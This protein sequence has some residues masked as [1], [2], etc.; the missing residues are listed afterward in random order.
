MPMTFEQVKNQLSAIEPGNSIF[1][2]IGP[3]EIPSLKK[4]LQDKEAWMAARAVFVLS[5]IRDAKATALL[6]QIVADSR[7]EIRVALAASAH[8]LKPDD[9]NDILVQLLGDADLGVRKFAVKSVSSAHN[10]AVH[11][12]LKDIK[13]RDPALPIRKIADDR[14]QELKL[15]GK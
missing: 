9:A 7:P 6:S 12:K 3:S 15:N 4:L 11:Q 1:S 14:L 10:T 2:G 13:L 8:N 5:R